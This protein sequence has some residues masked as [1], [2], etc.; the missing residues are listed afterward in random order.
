M[1]SRHCRKYSEGHQER[2]ALQHKFNQTLTTSFALIRLILISALV[3]I[4]Q[5]WVVFSQPIVLLH[6]TCS[7]RAEQIFPPTSPL[8]QKCSLRIWSRGSD[9]PHLLNRK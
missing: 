4:F 2:W 3:L 6:P 7:T 8:A 1:M 9:Y 5:V